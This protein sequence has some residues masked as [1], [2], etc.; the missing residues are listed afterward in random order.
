MPGSLFSLEMVVMKNEKEEDEDGEAYEAVAV[1]RVVTMMMVVVVVVLLLLLRGLETE[2]RSPRHPHTHKS[3]AQR[4]PSPTRNPSHTPH[5]PLL[6]SAFKRPSS[7]W[8]VLAQIVAH[9]LR[10]HFRQLYVRLRLTS[11]F[12]TVGLE[13]VPA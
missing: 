4:F 7:I 5:A 6:T 1:S 13:T 9:N 8:R 11:R 2:R 3:D 10:T 12:Y